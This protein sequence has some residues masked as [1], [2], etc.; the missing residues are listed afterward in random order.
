MPTARQDSRAPTLTNMKAA[1]HPPAA[2]HRGGNHTADR[3]TY[4]PSPLVGF[5]YE[6]PQGVDTRIIVHTELLFRY[7]NHL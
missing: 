6:I 5:L 3:R 7:I 2:P 4:C 1:R